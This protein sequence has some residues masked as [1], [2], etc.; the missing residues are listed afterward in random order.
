MQDGERL[1]PGGWRYLAATALPILLLASTL[2]VLLTRLNT[3]ID[4]SELELKGAT[5][6]SRL[7]QVAVDLQFYR[8][9]AKVAQERG[10][11]LPAEGETRL[12]TAR[13]RLRA[14]LGGT[15]TDIFAMR[16]DLAGIAG[17]FEELAKRRALLHVRGDPTH[18]VA[19][20]ELVRRLHWM[21]RNVA[22]RAQLVLEP[23]P[24]SYYWM[25]MIVVDLPNLVESIGRVRGYAAAVAVQAEPNDGERMVVREL[26]GGV[27]ATLEDVARAHGTVLSHNP[28]LRDT[29]APKFDGLET[30]VRSFLTYAESVLGRRLGGVAADALFTAGTSTIDKALDLYNHALR[31]FEERVRTRDIELR[32]VR[33][34][35]I[36]GSS[37]AFLLIA[38]FAASFYTQNRRAFGRL[39]DQGY[40][41]RREVALH[42]RTEAAL[43][44]SEAKW[45]SL[46]QNAPDIIFTVDRARRITFIN[47]TPAGLSLEE[48]A[49]KDV[50]GFIAPEHRAIARDAIDG[51]FE[52]GEAGAYEVRARGPHGE[53]AWFATRLGPVEG[54]DGRITSVMLIT[55]DVTARV[56]AQERVRQ[57]AGALERQSAHLQQVN[58]ELEQFAYVA[59]HDLKAPLRAVANLADWLEE[60]LEDRLNED[61]R[62]KFDLLRTRV[63]RMHRLI[64]AL[65]AY[66]RMGH[67]AGA[68]EAVDTGELLRE[69]I[70]S[71][72]IPEEF[73]ID[74]GKGMPTL[75]ADRLCLSQVF[76]NLVGNAIK[77]HDRPDG[78]IWVSV[79][80][81]GAYY[82][83]SIADDGPGI[84]AGHHERIFELFST[85]QPIENNGGTGIGL[86]LVKKLVQNNNGWITQDSTPGCGTTFRFFWPKVPSGR[87]LQC[88][89]N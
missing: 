34:R 3:S 16:S 54:E 50:L 41:L 44:E 18:F 4:R 55:R 79:K 45:R 37:L 86:A 10:E 68:T 49:H 28:R 48:A 59:S 7:H 2:S 1:R 52:T 63:M 78:H 22:D 71:F 61:E 62:E 11:P 25:E 64:E 57:S 9:L 73:S 51:V 56:E 15:S 65:L 19:A 23:D 20:T 5:Y 81:A 29:L 84:E 46:V 47:R 31:L 43:R 14:L 24:E 74:V 26:L 75:Q 69:V 6:V 58:E 8:G 40:D 87:E 35:A 70:S 21:M 89:E 83:F 33:A 80:D 67:A 17:D 66:S 30:S 76:A 82:E 72:A 12:E 53:P 38:Y 77:H 36:G 88:A 85:I 32:R 39:R 27:R 42:T 13:A 60:D